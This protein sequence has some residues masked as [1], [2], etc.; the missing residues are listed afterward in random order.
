M[1][2][3]IIIGAGTAGMTAAL[4]AARA[5]FSTL[6]FEAK[7]PGGQIL[8]APQVE[9]YPGISAVSGA[10]LMRS[11]QEQVLH[12]G[13][14]IKMEKVTGI[15]G[16]AGDFKVRTENDSYAARAVIIATGAAARRMGLPR[17]EELTGRGVSYCATCDG[18][19]FRGKDVAVVGGG[20][21]ALEDAQYLSAVCRK[22]YLIHRREEFRGDAANV[23]AVKKL[24]NVELVLSANVTEFL[25]DNKISGVRVSLK[26]GASRDLDVS[27]V[28]F[29]IGY[30]PQNEVFSDFVKV[31][32]NGYIETEDGVHTSVPGVYVAGDAR[33]KELKQLTTA[34]ADGAMAAMVAGKEIE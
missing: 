34:T 26:D 22:V 18:N 16:V 21:A 23:A 25:G 8:N 10:E 1:V 31:D 33:A 19:F 11:L 2:D 28:F 24:S 32:K 15:S 17:E 5:G 9:N 27:G 29:A 12:F 6:V 20:N 30:A 13:G 7:M 14:E 3:I 4:Y